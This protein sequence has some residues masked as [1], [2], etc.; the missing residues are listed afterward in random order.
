MNFAVSLGSPVTYSV[1]GA[2]AIRFAPY[3]AAGGLVVEI[4]CSDG[5]KTMLTLDNPQRQSLP[6]ADGR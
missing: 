2:R 4:E 6:S 3:A 1:N 5:A